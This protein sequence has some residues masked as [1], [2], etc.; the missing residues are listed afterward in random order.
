MR[1]GIDTYQTAVIYMRSDCHICRAEGFA[2]QSRVRVHLDGRSL[3]ATLNVVHGDLLQPGEAALSESAWAALRAT[4]G[5]TCHVTHAEPVASES[6]LRAKVYG[7][8]LSDAD[9]RLI[10]GD[11][12]ESRYSDLQLA[13][14]VTAVAGGRLDTTETL[15]LTRAMVAAGERIRWPYPVVADKHCVGGLPGNRTTPIV[16]AIVSAL[17]LAF[18]KTS[19]RAITSPAGTA[20][21]M[22]VLAPVN[23][24]LP[25]M[26][27]AVEREGGCI[28][29]GGAV[30]LSPADDI[31]IRAE[32]PLDLDSDGQLVAS[33]LSKKVAA[34]A[35]HVLIDVPIGPT[36]KIRS[37]AAAEA[38]TR[39]LREVGQALGLNIRMLRTDGNQPVGRGI[40]P[41]LE[42]RDLVAVLKG[43][44]DAPLDLRDRSLTL[45]AGILELCGSV[46]AGG[47]LA[48]AEQALAGGRAWK[49]FQ[50]I[51]DA[52]GGMRELPTAGLFRSIE[53]DQ[54]GVVSSIDNRG[55]ARAAK[56]AGAPGDKIAGAD[57]HVRLGDLVRR[58]Q[59]LFTLH[60]GAPGQLEYA[61]SFLQTRSPVISVVRAS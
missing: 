56:L 27:R 8:K 16:V 13:A 15:A 53:T 4:E 34:G 54:G 48:M 11:I 25:A 9:M 41:A 58:G 17:G 36:A 29:W 6:R 52:Q 55:L 5:D 24:D 22:E 45:A 42:A 47:G 37:E 50:A 23:L 59:P 46:T 40:G 30:N 60:A 51:C 38:L 49:K 3:A 61:M 26:R 20:D 32:R 35:T 10:V 12:V 33:I 14:F 57:I 19:S 2:A 1:L 39:R 21:T 18:P 28:V 7:E 43:D 31:L 44:R